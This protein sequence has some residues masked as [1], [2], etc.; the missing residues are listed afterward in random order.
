[1]TLATAED[2][3]RVTAPGAAAKELGINMFRGGDEVVGAIVAKRGM[4]IR[5]PYSKQTMHV[6]DALRQDGFGGGEVEG[7]SAAAC[8]KLA[9]VMHDV[10]VERGQ[11]VLTVHVSAGEGSGCRRRENIFEADDTTS[12]GSG[13]NSGSDGRESLTDQASAA[14]ERTTPSTFIHHFGQHF[15]HTPHAFPDPFDDLKGVG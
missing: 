12:V 10:Q 2:A 13:G 8:W 11:T 14:S 7:S 4:F 9:V 6:P 5:Y 15:S 3:R 1:M